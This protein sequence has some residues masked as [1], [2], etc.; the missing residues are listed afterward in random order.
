MK[1]N[2]KKKEELLELI[3]PDE[4]NEKQ[5]M[6]YVEEHIKN[7]ENTVQG[8]GGL[9]EEETYSNWLYK[10]RKDLTN[11]KGENG[12]VQST[13]YLAIRKKDNKLIGTIQIRHKLNEK[14]LNKGGNIGYGVRPEERKK[15]YATFML[16]LALKKAKE[17]KLNRILVTCNKENISSV[18]VILKNKG[19]LE[20]EIEVSKKEVIQRYWIDLK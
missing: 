17:L 8:I 12:R 1:K 20:N 4:K 11:T 18:K 15:G 9:A 6:E 5:I 19:K 14:L 2:I 7:G 10:I 13:L 3:I 16:E